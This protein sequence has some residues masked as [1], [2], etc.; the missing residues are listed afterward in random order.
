VTNTI[1]ITIVRSD[2]PIGASRLLMATALRYAIPI[3][4]PEWAGEIQIEPSRLLRGC[5]IP[6]NGDISNPGGDTF[7]VTAVELTEPTRPR[8]PFWVVV[9]V[10]GGTP[11]RGAVQVTVCAS[12]ITT[13]DEIMPDEL[14]IEELRARGE[15]HD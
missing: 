1:D 6:A 8:S 9:H 11:I 5:G 10:R 3:V 4:L 14:V 12:P 15:P 7:H 13:A 2:R